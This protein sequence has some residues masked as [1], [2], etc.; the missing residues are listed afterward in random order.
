MSTLKRHI[1]PAIAAVLERGKSVLFLGPRQTGKTTLLQAF[2]A[3]RFISFADPRERLRYEMEPGLLVAEV[4]G[5]EMSRPAFIVVDEVQK[6]PAIMDAV[7]FLIDKQIAQFV[8][9]GSSARKLRRGS[10]VN[11]L[12]GRVIPIYL[13]ALSLDELPAQALALQDL[14]MYGSLPE[15]TLTESL[16]DKEQL[17]ESYVTIYLE[18]EVRAEALV[19]NLAHFA[20]FLQLAA[21]EAGHIVNMSKLSQT[22]G[23]A[24]TTI[25]SYFQILQDCLI[26]EKIEPITESKTRHRLSKASKYLFF[27]LGVRRIAAHEGKRPPQKHLGHLFEQWVGIELIRQARRISSQIHLRY[28]RDQNGPEIDWVIE[29]PDELIP[30]E[31]K[32][33]D[34]PSVHDA[35]HI[36]SFINEYDKA[37][38]G[39]VICQTPQRMKLGREIYALSW[40]EL[41]ACLG[42]A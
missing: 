1:A 38:R 15:I 2:T 31:V 12:P 34:A 36:Q 39:Y 24:S 29:T 21:S 40:K 37:S 41:V 7:Q 4:E 8:L 13:D 10:D 11:L 30:I 23:V 32:W 25:E 33:S 5:M 3:D 6:V 20:K 18:E 28:W 16:Q 42:R 22:I 14:L 35:R 27:D 17:L 26:V 19:R 9:T